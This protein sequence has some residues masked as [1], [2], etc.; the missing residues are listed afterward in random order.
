M[1]REAIPKKIGIQ[2]LSNWSSYLKICLNNYQC[3]GI[4]YQDFLAATNSNN[5]S[6][7]R[8]VAYLLL[9]RVIIFTFRRTTI[10][11]DFPDHFSADHHLT[12]KKIIVLEPEEASKF[13][14]VVG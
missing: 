4:W 9:Y 5:S 3:S 13:S 1:A 7:T 14:Y 8:L 12:P 10:S 6:I 11:N 2:W